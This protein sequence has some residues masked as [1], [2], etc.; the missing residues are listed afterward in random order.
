MTNSLRA[1]MERATPEQKRVLASLAGTTIANL[2]QASKGYRTKGKLR[3]TPD[4]ARRLEFASQQIDDMPVL[5]REDL[6]P[7]CA[8]CEFAAKCRGKI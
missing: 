7:S 5:L 4:L 1:W 6:S 3:I 2:H 8:G